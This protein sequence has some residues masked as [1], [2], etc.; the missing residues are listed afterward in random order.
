M[1]ETGGNYE[2]FAK[3]CLQFHMKHYDHSEEQLEEYPELKEKSWDQAVLK[4]LQ[5]FREGRQLLM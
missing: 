5:T 2:E 1:S 3:F 4:E